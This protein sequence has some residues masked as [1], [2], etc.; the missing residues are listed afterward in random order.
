MYRSLRLA[1]L[2]ERRA[3]ASSKRSVVVSGPVISHGNGRGGRSDH[4]LWSWW[5]EGGRRKKGSGERES[6]ALIRGRDL[7][8]LV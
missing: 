8:K 7:L 5:R 4:L 3:I 6:D 2:V 1:W